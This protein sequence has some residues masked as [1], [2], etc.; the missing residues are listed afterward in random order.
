MS[1]S[2]DDIKNFLAVCNTLNITRASEVLGMTQPT[3]SYSIK[4][5]ESE[6]GAELITRQKNGVQLTKVGEEFL[7][8]AKKLV[9]LWEESQ[10]ILTTDN[11]NARG[12]FSLGVHPSVALYTLHLIFPKFLEKYPYI[13]FRLHHG[14]SREI[15]KKV[16]NWEIDFAL[17]INPIE[18]PD[19]VIHPLGEDIVT[20]FGARKQ[21]Q[22]LIY[23]PELAQSLFILKKLGKKSTQYNGHIHSGNLEVIAK[24]SASGLGHGLLPTRVAQNFKNLKAISG[25]PTFKDKICLIYRKEKHTNPISQK[26][27][28]IFK[29]TKL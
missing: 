27:I 29:Q 13:N 21:A 14:L 8:R 7:G 5:L 18:H 24:L 2:L 23:D 22:K 6:L 19:L 11:E 20:L 4:R 3:L 10:S 17:V 15:S 28:D 9:L 1:L 26:M 16:I 12:E 25:A